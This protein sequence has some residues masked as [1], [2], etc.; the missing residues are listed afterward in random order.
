[1]INAL[2]KL[3]G[4]TEVIDFGKLI[5]EGAVVLDVRSKDEFRLANLKGSTNIPLDQL[6]SG[7]SK[8]DKNLLIITCCASGMRSSSAKSLLESSG[9]RNV[10]NAGSWTHLMP[11]IQ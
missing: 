3:F 4:G 8:L 1:M 10:Y 5:A 7:V 6:V 9:F 11:Y 2:K